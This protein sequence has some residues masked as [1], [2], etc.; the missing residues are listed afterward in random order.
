IIIPDGK[1][2]YIPF[3]TLLT[4]PVA[5]Q[6]LDNFPQHPYLFQKSQLSLAFSVATLWDQKQH[7]DAPTT[8]ILAYAPAFRR[9]APDR[10]LTRSQLS[11]LPFNQLEASFLKNNF[12]AEVVLDEKATSRHFLNHAPD[13]EVLHLSTHG[14]VNR[15]NPD[16]S[17]IAFSNIPDDDQE[18]FKITVG[19]IY[20]QNLPCEMVVLSACETGIGKAIRGEGI[21]SIAR[22]FA[23][24]GTRS[25]V[26]SLWSVNEE[27]TTKVMQAFYEH[28]SQQTGTTKDAALQAAMQD[29]LNDPQLDLLKKSPKYW[30][31]FTIIGDPAPIQLM[32]ERFKMF[33]YWMVGIGLVSLLLI[34]RFLA[35]KRAW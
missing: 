4:E 12:A 1:L 33:P 30:A 9:P 17:F 5:A 19:D 8:K 3:H 15:E 29:Y 25:V 34:G 13:A 2:G 28:L 21:M 16:L 6:E 7:L 22:A 18:A 20:A 24:A 27:K 35:K 14:K 32:G 23:Y 11:E 31:A 10:N 26:T